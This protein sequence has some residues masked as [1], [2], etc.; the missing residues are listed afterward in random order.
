VDGYKP[1]QRDRA[2]W[3]GGLALLLLV[4][5]SS[6]SWVENMGGP[7]GLSSTSVAAITIATLMIVTRCVNIGDARNALDLQILLT[8]VGALGLGSALHQT[9]AAGEIARTL[10]ATVGDRPYLTLIVVYVLGVVFTEMITN[11]AVA[12]L[13][14]PL[15]ID[16][17]WQGGYNPRPFVMA[18]ALS[19]SLS[20]MTP[21]GYQ[22]NLMVMGP[23]NYRP[24]DY[25]R[26]GVPLSALVAATS[27]IL[28]PRIWPLQ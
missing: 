13:L 21:V 27:L 12:A 20:F 26:A 1:R 5:M 2:L 11:N 17:A 19:A 8:I 7:S 24:I 4:W 28:I 14:I 25:L 15:A 6:T 3:A 9:G 10:V 23:G 16:V 22:T 18:I